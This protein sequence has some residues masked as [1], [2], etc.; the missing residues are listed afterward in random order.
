M[1]TLPVVGLKFQLMTGL[2]SLI[3]GFFLTDFLLLIF[4]PGWMQF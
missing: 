3:N 2:V 1:G 4:C